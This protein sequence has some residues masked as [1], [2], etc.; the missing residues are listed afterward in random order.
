MKALCVIA[1]VLTTAAHASVIE[2]K[3]PNGQ[4]LLTSDQSCPAG[5][6]FKR[7]IVQDKRSP[8]TPAYVNDDELLSSMLPSRSPRNPDTPQPTKV[9]AYVNDDKFIS[10]I[11][12]SQNQGKENAPQAT[13]INMT[14]LAIIFIVLAALAALMKSNKGSKIKLKNEEAK[15]KKYE[16]EYEANTRKFGSARFKIKNKTLLTQREQECFKRLT[17][18]L[19]PDFLVFPQVAFSQIIDTEGG[20]KFDNEGLRR[21][22]SQKVA[23]F[24]VCKPDLTMIAIIELDDKSHIGKEEKDKQR[25]SIVRQIGLMPL[26]IPR[27]PAQNTLD[28]YARVLRKMHPK[29]VKPAT[30]PAA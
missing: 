4:S 29:E 3:F 27:T 6:T 30:A 24:V 8:Q 16:P 11:P 10:S 7:P 25:D 9:P 1:L 20:S 5:T 23:D 19:H 26:R 15:A 17:Q 13:G 18:S 21:T 22:M 12:P 2:C 28:E 14:T